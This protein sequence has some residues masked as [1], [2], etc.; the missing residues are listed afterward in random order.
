MWSQ[1]AKDSGPLSVARQQ[2]PERLPGHGSAPIRDEQIRA[3]APLQELGPAASEIY[4]NGP[5]RRL[6]YWNDPVLVALADRPD[7]AHIHLELRYSHPAEF[8][9]AQARGV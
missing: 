7:E 9:Y 1:V 8:G 4:L 5:E 6:A 3:R 2:L